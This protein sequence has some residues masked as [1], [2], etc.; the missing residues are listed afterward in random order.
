MGRGV[1]MIAVVEPF[2]IEKRINRTAGATSMRCT[3]VLVQ[4]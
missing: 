2:V 4:M 1:T 3:G